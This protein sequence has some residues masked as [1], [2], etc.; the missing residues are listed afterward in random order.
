LCGCSHFGYLKI[1]R[2]IDVQFLGLDCN[3]TRA[4]FKYVKVADV[5]RFQSR[6]IDLLDTLAQIWSQ[7]VHALLHTFGQ[8][9]VVTMTYLNILG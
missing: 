8:L 3:A 7:I 2:T 9:R 5:K 6:D 4:A 1:G